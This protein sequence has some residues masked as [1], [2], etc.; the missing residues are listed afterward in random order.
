M[1]GRLGRAS[2]VTLTL[3]TQAQQDGAA[4][5]HVRVWVGG[6]LGGFRASGVS[7]LGDGR[8]HVRR[9]G[10][11]WWGKGWSRPLSWEA[12]WNSS[13]FSSLEAASLKRL[14]LSFKPGR[15]SAFNQK[16]KYENVLAVQP[17]RRI[18]PRTSEI[19]LSR[20][21]LDYL[22][23]LTPGLTGLCPAR[24]L[25]QLLIIVF[26][27][28]MQ[29]GIELSPPTVGAWSPDPWTSREAPRPHVLGRSLL[30]KPRLQPHL[31]P[32][33]GRVRQGNRN[34][35]SSAGRGVAQADT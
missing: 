13:C 5:W 21:R 31:H 30:P 3:G 17:S 2:P 14:R 9:V 16:L 29:H 25:Q 28:A 34:C 19:R 1:W 27:R 33:P 23:T 11:G 32:L 12:E 20:V 10:A 15:N 22:C 24:E 35:R 4:S 7:R 26:G 6:H 8:A 18:A